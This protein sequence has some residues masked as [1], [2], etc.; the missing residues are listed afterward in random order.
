MH[1]RDAEK[2]KERVGQL[3]PRVVGRGPSSADETTG[4][5][6]VLHQT[7]LAWVPSLLVSLL[8]A[9]PDISTGAG[10]SDDALVVH[11][12]EFE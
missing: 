2:E 1:H 7:C 9:I 5:R 8:F 10:F 6:V 12:Q 4:R 11:Q 3:G